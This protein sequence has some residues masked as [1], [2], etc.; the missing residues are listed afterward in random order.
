LR[1]LT[2]FDFGRT[3]HWVASQRAIAKSVELRRRSEEQ[4]VVLD[5]KRAYFS[6]LEAQELRVVAEET[7]KSPILQRAEVSGPDSSLNSF[8]SIPAFVK[9]HAWV[10][11]ALPTI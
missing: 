1:S 5:V 2:V 8:N 6:V 7:V 9:L 10:Y 11:R 3:K 4:R